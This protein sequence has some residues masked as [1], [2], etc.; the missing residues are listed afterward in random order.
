VLQFENL[1]PRAGLGN[2]EGYEVS[3]SRFDNAAQRHEP[4]GAAST[5]AEPEIPIPPSDAEF[6]AVS[7]RTMAAAQPAWAS[8]V[9][10]FLRRAG[11]GREVVGIER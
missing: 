6:L 2:V 1:G 10:V 9:R 7:I 3:W 5:L 4:L 11:D 8:P